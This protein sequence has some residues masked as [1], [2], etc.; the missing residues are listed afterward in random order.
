MLVEQTRQLADAL[1]LLIAAL[2]SGDATGASAV[3]IELGRLAPSIA[4]AAAGGT[5]T[6]SR[7]LGDQLRRVQR[8]LAAC[9]RIGTAINECAEAAL[10]RRG[11]LSDYGPSGER[12]SAAASPTVKARA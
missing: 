8:S 7:E 12:R 2:A 5:F 10:A 4:A 3:E 11:L 9:R 1:D 6:Q